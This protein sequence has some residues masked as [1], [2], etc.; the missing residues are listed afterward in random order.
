MKEANVGDKIVIKGRSVMI[1]EIIHQEFWERFG[2]DIE[3]LD[4][5]GNYHHW[6][7]YEDGGELIKG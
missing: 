6:K 7:Q 5:R 3:F 1:K 2:F 4:G